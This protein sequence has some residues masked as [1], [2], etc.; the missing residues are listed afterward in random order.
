MGK[1]Q[2]FRSLRSHCMQ[3]LKPFQHRC[4]LFVGEWYLWIII[5]LKE[6][7][8]SVYYFIVQI[9]YLIRSPHILYQQTSF[10]SS[11]QTFLLCHI[12]FSSLVLDVVSSTFPRWVGILKKIDC[13]GTKPP[14]KLKMNICF[15]QEKI[16]YFSNSPWHLHRK[17]SFA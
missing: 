16:Q 12:S 11:N 7:T 5:Q 17:T 13:T 14:Q 4:Q 6:H 15:L 2:Y 3:V 10:W 8:F 9:D 1:M